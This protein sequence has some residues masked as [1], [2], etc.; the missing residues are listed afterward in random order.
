MYVF[1]FSICQIGLIALLH[2]ASLIHD[3]T[4]KSM[5]PN[6]N[7]DFPYPYF[8]PKITVWTFAG[9]RWFY[10]VPVGFTIAGIVAL[11]KQAPDMVLL[12]ILA[13][14]TITSLVLCA[15]VLVGLSCPLIVT[16]Y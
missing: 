5:P 10:L 12:S 8:L 2:W 15:F 14:L 3:A 7:P 4:F 1:A 9:V 13:G 11:R 16:T 6:N